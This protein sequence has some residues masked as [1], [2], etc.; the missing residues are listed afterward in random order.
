VLIIAC[1]IHIVVAQLTP[2][3]PARTHVPDGEETN[4]VAT[5]QLA[6]RTW[7]AAHR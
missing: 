1:G 2:Q 3:S 5:M 6:N 4:K 7:E